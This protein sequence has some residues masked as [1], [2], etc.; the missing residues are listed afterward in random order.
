MRSETL[1]RIG[2]LYDIENAIRGAPPDRRET[3]RQGHAKPKIEAFR[4]WW[5]K[6]LTELPRSSSTAEAIRYA[7]IRWASLCRFL[8][9]GTVEIDDNAAGCSPDRTRRRARAAILSL[10]ESAKLNGLNPEAYLRDV[11]TRIADHPINRIDD[12]LPWNIAPEP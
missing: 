1:V 12:L 10:I 11:L 8:D 2:E 5:D 3:V 4:R 9:D 7:I 6:M